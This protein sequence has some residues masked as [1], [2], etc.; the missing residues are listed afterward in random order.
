MPQFINSAEVH[1]IQQPTDGKPLEQLTQRVE[2][3]DLQLK[4]S[5]EIC[6]R[7]CPRHQFPVAEADSTE[8]TSEHKA[9]LSVKGR[10]DTF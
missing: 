4:K 10:R 9:L 6:R 1:A 7:K 8:D 2:K 3:I 5:K